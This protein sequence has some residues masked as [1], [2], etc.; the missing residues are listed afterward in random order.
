MR[1]LCLAL[2]LIP[3][4]GGSSSGRVDSGPPPDVAL[5]DAEVGGGACNAPMIDCGGVCVD[6]STDSANC[7]RCGMACGGGQACGSGVCGGSPTACPPG[8]VDCGGECRD[9]SADPEQCGSCS[10][11]CGDEEYCQDGAC[12]CRPRYS[13]CGGACVDTTSDPA[14]CGDCDTPCAD[15]CF[16]GACVS[17]D[18]CTETVCGGSCVD[19]DIDPL[20]CGSCTNAC[21]RDQIC[22]AGQCW[23]YEPA[24]DC[25]SCGDCSCP[26]SET[27]CELTGYGVSC[28]DTSVG[29]L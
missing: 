29:C 2:V 16:S 18:A 5:I 14:H 1:R 6:P 20:H 3:A 27:C 4:C 12:V 28:V 13:E 17:A 15:V 23:D 22:I 11:V 24:V 25:T 26:D 7:G 21:A 19:L 10:G 9:V 8:Y